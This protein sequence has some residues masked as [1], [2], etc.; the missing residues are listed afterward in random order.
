MGIGLG[1]RISGAVWILLQSTYYP[2]RSSPCVV[3][4][5]SASIWRKVRRGKICGIH[6]IWEQRDRED[7]HRCSEELVMRLEIGLGEQR[8]KRGYAGSLFGFLADMAYS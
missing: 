6:R 8:E 5:K 7:C 2:G 3:W 4:D 1:D